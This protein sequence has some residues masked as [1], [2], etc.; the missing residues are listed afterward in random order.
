MHTARAL[1]PGDLPDDIKLVVADM[2]GT[3][4]DAT[5]GIPDSFWPMLTRLVERG[6]VFAPASGRQY[7]A[8]AGMFAQAGPGVAL[9]AENGAFVVRD[10]LE[11]SS[12]LV[13]P[14]FSAHAVTVAREV[15]RVHNIGFVWSGR[16]SAY[17]ERG[18]A[19]FAEQ[20]GRFYTSLEVVDDLMQVPER[21]LKF[22]VFD[23][24]GG[25][26]GSRA[27]LTE[28]LSPFQVVMSS[29]NWM[30]IMDPGVNKGVALRALRL[31]LDATP[32]Q[33]MVF[34]D[35]LNDLEMFSEATHSFA[36][37]N[38]HPKLTRA[39]RYIAPSNADHGV[40]S[41]MAQLLGMPFPDR[42]PVEARPAA[43]RVVPA[44]APR[45]A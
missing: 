18:D 19:A 26:A 41:T 14:E 43:S 9:I 32:D 42:E 5:G 40:I 24:D 30:D 33:T 34:G 17:V 1:E 6:I 37:A 2:D 44:A 25:S 35:Y 45:I 10:G 23:F 38:A 29:E 4:L 15:A 22:A 20:A 16:R 31:S 3:L 8:L 21:A 11:V 27:L 13:D 7:T 12:S 39:A 28:A 36:M